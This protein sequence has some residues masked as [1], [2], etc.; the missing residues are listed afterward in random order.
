MSGRRRR[1]DQTDADDEQHRPHEEECEVVYELIES[2]PDVVTATDVAIDDPYDRVEAAPA[3]R[4]PCCHRRRVYD[5]SIRRPVDPDGDGAAIASG[6]GDPCH[7][8][9]TC[10]GSSSS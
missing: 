1:A 10:V 5:S 3:E 2:G 4:T 9:V 6:E 7:C 8:T